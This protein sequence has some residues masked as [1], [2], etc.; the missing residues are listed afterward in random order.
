M[1]LSIASWVVRP[2]VQ[3][4][5]KIFER[6]SEGKFLFLLGIMHQRFNDRN[7]SE[8]SDQGS[9]HGGVVARK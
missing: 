1:I 4:K 6:V 3:G 9:K 8:S 2:E 5:R 7:Q